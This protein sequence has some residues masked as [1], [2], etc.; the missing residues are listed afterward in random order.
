MKNTLGYIRTEQEELK[1]ELAALGHIYILQYEILLSK[2]M[3]IF[4]KT[5]I[6]YF[7][8]FKLIVEANYLPVTSVDL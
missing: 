1:E 6:F 2:F 3:N 5:E 8:N 7:S 4:N